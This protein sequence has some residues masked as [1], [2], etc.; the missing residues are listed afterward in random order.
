MCVCVCVCVYECLCVCVSLGF[1]V[2]S[3]ARLEANSVSRTV[4]VNRFEAIE[5]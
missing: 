1:K 4:V 3:W 5:A 2:I